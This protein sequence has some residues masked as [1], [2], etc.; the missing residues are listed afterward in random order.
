[1]KVSGPIVQ[2]LARSFQKAYI[3]AGGED[4]RFIARQFATPLGRAKMELL[5]RWP[6][7]EKNPLH[8]HYRERLQNAQKSITILTPYFIPHAWLLAELKKATARDVE[9]EVIVAEDADPWIAKMVSKIAIASVGASKIRF[10]ATR[11]IHHAKALLI[12]DHEGMVGSPNIDPLSFDHNIEAGIFFEEESLVRD[13][14]ATI[15]E[16]KRDAVVYNPKDH[17][18][19]W[20]LS[21]FVP[22]F[23]LLQ[24]II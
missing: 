7:K 3:A 24:S 2:T 8:A 6:G 21:I 14:R 12:D 15:E 20:Y 22:V 13:L 9:V 11:D 1:M 17:A 23:R 4:T 5:E 10:Y 16:W 18:L 19:P